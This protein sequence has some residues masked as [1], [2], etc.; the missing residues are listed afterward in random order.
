MLS[1]IEE[2]YKVYNRIFDN[3]NNIGGSNDKIIQNLLKNSLYLSVFTVFENFLKVLINDYL[4]N[5][6]GRGVKFDQ[7]SDGV[8]CAMFLSDE[9]RIKGIF[10]KSGDAQS[11]AFRSYFETIKKNISKQKLE[12]H[13]RFEFLHESKLN[14]YYKDLFE[15]IIGERDFLTNLK[16]KE[17]FDD[18]KGLLDI[19]GDAFTFLREF[20]VNIRNNIAHGNQEFSIKGYY[21]FQ[22]ITDTFLFIMR[23][24]ADRYEKYNSIKLEKNEK[25]M[26]SGF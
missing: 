20:T 13:V 26:L 19:E 25:N 24:L 16:L 8:A 2:Q 15:Q 10:S 6:V 14:G 1:E 21:S 5:I 17:E 3:L 9:K 12:K 11:N 23:E 7:L 22:K 4:E 18:F